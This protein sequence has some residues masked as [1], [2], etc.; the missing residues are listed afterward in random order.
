MWVY[1]VMGGQDTK[2]FIPPGKRVSW[3]DAMLCLGD[4]P[5]H[6]FNDPD[7]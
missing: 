4:I 1:E 7:L 5:G 3:I 6:G 2:G